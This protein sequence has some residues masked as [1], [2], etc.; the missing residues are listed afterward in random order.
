MRAILP[1][2]ALLSL[3]PTLAPAQTSTDTVPRRG[4]RLLGGWIGASVAPSTRF[5]PI[6]DRHFIVAALRAQ[7]LLDTFGSLAFAATVDVVPLAILSNT[8][9]YDALSVPEPDGSF[10]TFKTVTGRSAVFGAG[11]MP[12]GLRFYT[13]STRPARLFFGGSGGL[14]W[15]TR[16]TP[17]PNA[18]RFNF[19]VEGGAGAE[20]LSR[21]GRAVVVGYKFQHLSNGETAPL[22]PGFDAH[23]L[24][25]G[26]MRPRGARRNGHGEPTV[27]R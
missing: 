26:M 12:A 20:F 4:E 1:L 15:F 2:Y 6:D 9:T 18:R 21:D 27:A 3:A 7:Y 5:G 22:N 16:D 25:V 19:A 17:V 11:I 10:V 14:L 23:L 13:I 24:Y 8:P